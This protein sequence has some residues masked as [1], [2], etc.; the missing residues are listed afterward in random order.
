MLVQLSIEN[1][2]L[3]ISRQRLSFKYQA[4]AG[5]NMKMLLKKMIVP[6]GA[7]SALLGTLGSG[8][9]AF[10]FCPCIL[11]PVFSLIGIFSL[12]M[13]FLSDY[14]FVFLGIGL[15]LLAVGIV[16]YSKKSRCRLHSCKTN[17][18]NKK[19]DD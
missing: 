16:L 2:M 7:A 9:A 1:C 18:N 6:L 17:E 4:D 13:S 14:R 8:I 3:I 12:T 15:M 5:P 11:A 10:G 19:I